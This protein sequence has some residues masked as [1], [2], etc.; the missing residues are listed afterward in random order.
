MISDRTWDFWA[1]SFYYLHSSSL[2]VRRIP[3]FGGR[4][5]MIQLCPPLPCVSSMGY[6]IV[7]GSL[8][9]SLNRRIARI[10]LPTATVIQLAA[11]PCRTGDPKPQ[12]TGLTLTIRDGPHQGGTEGVERYG[13]YVRS[14]KFNP[15]SLKFFA[16]A[17]S[18]ACD[19]CGISL[20][21]V[22]RCLIPNYQNSKN[23]GHFGLCR[24]FF[25]IEVLIVC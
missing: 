15:R 16:G 6:E 5:C 17:L 8:L 10:Q 18:L 23:L 11:R 4:R 1:R 14:S 21:A 24:M 2:G 13:A 19:S 20:I 9:T 7:T 12:T 25:I 22:G 3:I